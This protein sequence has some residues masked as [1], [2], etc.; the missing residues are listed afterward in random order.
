MR[1]FEGNFVEN[2]NFISFGLGLSPRNEAKQG[3]FQKMP[4]FCQDGVTMEI[5]SFPFLSAQEILR[6]LQVRTLILSLCLE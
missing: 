3:E 1:R 2:R 4:L 5:L 6:A